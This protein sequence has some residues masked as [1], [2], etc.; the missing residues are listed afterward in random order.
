MPIIGI[1][2]HVPKDDPIDVQMMAF[3][4]WL[5]IKNIELVHT[6]S[7]LRLTKKGLDDFL[8]EYLEK[9]K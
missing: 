6:P 4:E 5:K 7:W 1:Q 2:P 3:I 8:S 9:E